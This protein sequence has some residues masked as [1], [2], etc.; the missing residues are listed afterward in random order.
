MQEEAYKRGRERGFEEGYINGVGDRASELLSGAIRWHRKL[1]ERDIWHCF[2]V[3]REDDGVTVCY[4]GSYLVRNRCFIAQGHGV[5]HVEDVVMW[6]EYR[7]VVFSA[8]VPNG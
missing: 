1:P 3:I 8:E 4:I 7:P 6:G 5:I 2:I